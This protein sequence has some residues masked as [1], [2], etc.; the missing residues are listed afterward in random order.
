MAVLKLSTPG[1][2]VQEIPAL[3]PSVAEVETAIPAFIGYTEKADKLSAGDLVM[4]P[5]KVT[6]L[7]DYVQFYGTGPEESDD[8]IFVTVSADEKTVTLSFKETDPANPN[9]LKDKS[10][11]NLYY[12]IKHFYDNGGGTCYIVS[13][14][15]YR[16]AGPEKQPLL[17]GLK[18]IEDIDEVTI[19]V[20]PEANKIDDHAAV[21]P[22]QPPPPAPPIQPAKPQAYVD[23]V[24]A[25]IKQAST[26]KD[27]FALIDPFYITP[28]NV[29]DPNGD[30][31]R[32]VSMIRDATM[33]VTE[34]KYAAAYYPNLK[35]SYAYNYNLTKVTVKDGPNTV[36]GKKI[37]DLEGSAIYN[38][39]TGA[40][41]RLWSYLLLVQ[42]PVF[43]PV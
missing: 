30:I 15:K 38:A 1:V 37:S 26:L 7:Q 24:Q 43:T 2:Y 19:L 22:V 3:P 13:V 4:I 11:H 21:F 17:N 33:T 42:W 29:N 8:S 40:I 32:D 14:G 5:N 10:K 16:A 31:D 35:S 39:I 27:R 36:K 18:S 9:N 34:N 6:S 12:S 25:M 23:I 41:S 28:K 20:V